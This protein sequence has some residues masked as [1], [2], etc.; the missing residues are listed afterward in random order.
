MQRAAASICVLYLSVSA[1][2]PQ[3][4]QPTAEPAPLAVP[5]VSSTSQASAPA[6]G[7]VTRTTVHESPRTVTHILRLAAGAEISEHH[8]P[9]FDETF[10]VQQGSLQVRLNGQPYELVAGSVLVIPAGTVIGG[11]NSGAGEAVAVVV[12]S[13]IGRAGSL[14]VPGHPAH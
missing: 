9:F 10:I 11:R 2:V 7:T 8:H 3:V 6:P 12:F 14:T 1:C 5:R 13:N 4:P